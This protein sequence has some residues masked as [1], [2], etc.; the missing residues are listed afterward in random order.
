MRLWDART[1]KELR[2]WDA[3]TGGGIWPIALSPDGRTVAASRWQ[4]GTVRL[5]EAATGQLRD[6]FEGAAGGGWAVAFA[7]DGCTA[8]GVGPAGVTAWNAW[9]GKKATLASATALNSVACSADGR[10]L[11]AGDATGNVFVWDIRALRDELKAKGAKLTV[12]EVDDYWAS[13]SDADAEKAFRA[14]RGLVSSPGQAVTV[15]R[16]A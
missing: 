4:S 5:W 6:S 12:H 8:F 9:T 10:T 1:W 16:D 15:L 2:D 3:D 13:L 11:A 7:P 14:V